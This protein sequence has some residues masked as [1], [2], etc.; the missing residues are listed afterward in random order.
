MASFVSRLVGMIPLVTQ[1]D[2]QL[3]RH[4]MCTV[5]ISQTIDDPSNLL[6][7]IQALPAFT[8]NS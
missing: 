7:G 3:I 6:V 5:A 1:S 8:V 4:Q 2:V